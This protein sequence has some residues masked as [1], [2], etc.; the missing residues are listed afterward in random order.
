MAEYTPVMTTPSRGLKPR[1]SMISGMIM[2]CDDAVSIA[3][4]SGVRPRGPQT[5]ASTMIKFFD[6]SKG[7]SFTEGSAA[8]ANR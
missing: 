6:G 5:A 2:V 3:S 4:L 8:P 7:V 1:S